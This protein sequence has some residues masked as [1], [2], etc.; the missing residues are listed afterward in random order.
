MQRVGGGGEIKAF[1]HVLADG[2]E[3]DVESELGQAALAFRAED[4]VRLDL[5]VPQRK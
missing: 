5:S 2:I 4:R 3:E 1:D